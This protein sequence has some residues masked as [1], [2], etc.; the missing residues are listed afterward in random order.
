[1][2]P[3]QQENQA[4]NNSP[5]PP[6][7]FPPQPEQPNPSIEQA[8]PQQP[9]Q[10][11]GIYNPTAQPQQQPYAMQQPPY[12]NS[13]Q[14]QMPSTQ[15]PSNPINKKRK[16][17]IIIASCAVGVILLIAVILLVVSAANKNS[18]GGGFSLSSLIGDN[19][20]EEQTFEDAKLKIALPNNWDEPT[21]TQ[22][23]SVAGLTSIDAFAPYSLYKDTPLEG[24]DKT[25]ASITITA[26]NASDQRNAIS[27]EEYVGSIKEEVAQPADDEEI[28][29]SEETTVDGKQA[30]ITEITSPSALEG[31]DPYQ[32][33]TYYVYANATSIYKIEFRYSDQ[34]TT[35]KNQI[36]DIVKSI[37]IL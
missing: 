34:D 22:N 26:Y 7:P 32:T 11:P 33:K 36:N 16:L 20:L 35:F 31:G 25:H 28:T 37:R 17:L 2:Q 27:Y 12:P 8:A 9:L 19:N 1:M 6:S 24:F 30:Y 13:M 3:N 23:E 4:P 29:L 10:Q 14:P 18:E 15:P 5:V 21:V